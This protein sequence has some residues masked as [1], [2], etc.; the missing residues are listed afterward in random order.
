[1]GG[2]GRRAAGAAERALSRLRAAEGA[3]RHGDVGLQA[4]AMTAA[5]TAGVPVP[6][7]YDHGD[8][9]LGRGRPYLLTERLDGETIPRRLLRDEAYAAARPR[10]A[11]RLGEVLARIH[12]ADP[13]SVPGLPRADALGQALAVAEEFA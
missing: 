11:H 9:A 7:V 10:L 1:G 12:R 4:G 2:G 8:E 6:E 13:D 3:A 5:R